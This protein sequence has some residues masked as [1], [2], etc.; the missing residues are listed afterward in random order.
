[1]F[2]WVDRYVYSE[3]FYL[4]EMEMITNEILEQ[5]NDDKV[6]MELPRV[7]W[8]KSQYDG[9]FGRLT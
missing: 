3:L 6:V 2:L 5:K 8:K 7:R 1:M 4:V 9:I